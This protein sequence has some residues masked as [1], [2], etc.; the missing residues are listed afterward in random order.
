MS[1]LE[2]LMTQIKGALNDAL[3]KASEPGRTARQVIRDLEE[4]IEK[5]NASMVN[6]MA[7]YELLKQKKTQY[8]EEAN[9]WHERAKK[10]LQ[11]NREDLA[12]KALEQEEQ[13]KKQADIYQKQIEALEPSINELKAKIQELKNKKQEL[14]SKA[15][16]LSTRYEVA[17]AQEKASE[18]TTGIGDSHAKEKLDSVEEKV[19]KEEAKAK[20]MKNIEDEQTGADIEKEFENLDKASTVDDKL[21]ALKKEMGLK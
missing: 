13:A 6:V 11:A 18:I 3:D 21:E 20:A 12:K 1:F 16:I 19:L 15:D 14:E 7:E 4:Q 8:E 5:A 10:A 9:E 2:N 17:K